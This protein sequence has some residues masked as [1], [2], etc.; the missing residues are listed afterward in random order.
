MKLNLDLPAKP[1]FKITPT[2]IKLNQTHKYTGKTDIIQYDIE[3]YEIEAHPVFQYFNFTA[4]W[5][6]GTRQAIELGRISFKFN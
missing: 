1:L 4:S 5:H 3:T 6:A 2:Y